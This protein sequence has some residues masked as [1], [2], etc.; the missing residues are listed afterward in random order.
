MFLT[1]TSRLIVDYFLLVDYFISRLLVDYRLVDGSLTI[2]FTHNLTCG[3]LYSSMLLHVNL[4]SLAARS[5]ELS[6]RFFRDIMD[7]VSCLQ[8]SQP[9]SSTQ[10]HRYH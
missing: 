5:E 7:P 4:D 6:R 10:I 8:S 1:S 9:L 3:M 2:H